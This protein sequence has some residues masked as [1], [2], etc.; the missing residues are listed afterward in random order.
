M[1]PWLVPRCPDPSLRALVRPVSPD[2][3]SGA[4]VRL[5]GL[6]SWSVPRVPI[7]PRP[8]V[9]RFVLCAPDLSHGAL[10]CTAALI[11]S[12]GS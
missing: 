3:S 12:A 5:V 10:I 8:A 6:W 11:R 1:E 7:R 9:P 4:L 2:L